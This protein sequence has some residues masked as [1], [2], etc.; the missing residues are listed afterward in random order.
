VQSPLGEHSLGAS[1]A[2]P[3][4]SKELAELEAKAKQT[5]PTESRLERMIAEKNGPFGS[6]EEAL[7]GQLA[8]DCRNVFYKPSSLLKRPRTIIGTITISSGN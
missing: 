4:L 2:D 3:E 6:G 7:D 8:G 5:Q 1:G